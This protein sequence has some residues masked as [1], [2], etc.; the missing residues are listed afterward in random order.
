MKRKQFSQKIWH[1]IK[2]GKDIPKMCLICGEDDPRILRKSEKH[3]VFSKI[4]SDY[5]ILTCPNC[6]T[7]ITYTQNSLS[8]KRRSKKSSKMDKICYQ[9]ISQGELLEQIGKRN[10]ELAIKLSQNEQT[11]S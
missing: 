7:K 11:I 5:I 9:L 8:P 6:H 4:N 3:H 2:E 1:C 10:K